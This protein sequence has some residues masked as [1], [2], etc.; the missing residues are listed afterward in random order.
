MG[1]FGTQDGANIN[2]E[3]DEEGRILHIRGNGPMGDIFKTIRIANAETLRGYSEKLFVRCLGSAR[4][5][6]RKPCISLPM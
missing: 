3:Y 4:R 2:W 1:R 5:Q 6:R